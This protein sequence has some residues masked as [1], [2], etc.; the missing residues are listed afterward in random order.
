MIN[1]FAALAHN[2]TNTHDRVTDHTLAIGMVEGHVQTL[3]TALKG[4]T[5]KVMEHEGLTQLPQIPFTFLVDRPL[6]MSTNQWILNTR[7]MKNAPSRGSSSTV[8]QTHPSSPSPEGAPGN[9][10]GG[11]GWNPGT[12]VNDNDSCPPLSLEQGSIR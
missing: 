2:V 9:P 12:N 8:T 7:G 6:K 10:G 3:G 5:D 4:L 1:G 11:G